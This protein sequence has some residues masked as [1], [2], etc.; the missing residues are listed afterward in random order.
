MYSQ[1]LSPITPDKASF[2]GTLT[3]FTGPHLLAFNLLMGPML[4]PITPQLLA[5]LLIAHLRF[6]GPNQ[7]G[8]SYVRLH[9]Y[10]ELSSAGVIVVAVVVVVE[11]LG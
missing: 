6:A 4:S 9:C 8:E 3:A 10:Y 7:T 5:Y 2:L 1:I 11:E